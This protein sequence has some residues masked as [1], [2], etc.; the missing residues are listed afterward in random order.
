[1]KKNRLQKYIL[2]LITVITFINSTLLK[3]NEQNNILLAPINI[4]ENNETAYREDLDISSPENLYRI[5]KTA[6]FGTE[7]ITQE[8]I[9]AQNP[10][11]IFDLLNKTTGL[12]LTYQGRKHP[13]F[14]NMRGG[15]N[16]TYI[17]DGAILP[18]AADR[19]LY[20]I[21]MSAIEEIQIVKNSTTL[22]LAPSIEIGAS[23][24]GSGTNIGFIIIR[25]KHPKKTEGIISTFYE[26][27][28]SHPGANGQNIY[29]GTTFN[30]NGISGYIGGMLNRFNR[31]SDIDW[32]DGNDGRSGMINGG[33]S[34]GSLT[35]NIMGYKDEGRF[36]MQKGVDTQGNISPVEWY[37]DPLKTSLIS[38]DGNYIWNENQITLFSLSNLKYQQSEHSTSDKYYKEKT[39]TYSLRHNAQFNDTSIQIGTQLTNSE[40]KGPNLSYSYND[41]E[42]TVYGYA[43]SLEQSLFNDDLILNAGYRRDQKIIDHSSSSRTEA[44]FLNN[45]NAN[46]NSDLA[47]ANVYVLGALYNIDD[48]HKINLRYMNSNEGGGGDFNLITQSGEPLDEEKQTRWELG[49]EG[50]YSKAFNAIITYFDVDIKNEKTATSNTYLDSDGNEYYYYTESDSTRSGLEIALNGRINNVTRYKFSYTRMLVNTTDNNDSIG[51]S[52]P[53]NLYTAS[54]NHTY[55]KYSFNISAKKASAY[56]SS[57]SAMGT[58]TDV[59]LG[60]YTRVDANVSKDFILYGLDT[61]IKI[62]GR[63]I[64]DEQYATRYTTGYYYDRGRTIGTEL[65]LRF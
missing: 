10:K 6:Q 64:T 1:M 51:T 54:L 42:T 40:G 60:D 27:A 15:G 12:D 19:I 41:Y 52:T 14:I 46:N 23:N 16:I 5:E 43:I 26:K 25:T 57:T 55:G 7:V 50:N 9:E 32:F 33:I 49:L 28:E 59:H 4:E 44:Q 53:K 37:Y 20:K 17:I 58:S 62:Y 45:L 47:P 63:N 13:Y 22:T 18:Q 38:F 48:T 2:S 24:S 30:N 8:E 29:A 56:T 65:S 61:T 3:A 36:E 11:D 34:S 21:P 35:L 39:Q 31:P